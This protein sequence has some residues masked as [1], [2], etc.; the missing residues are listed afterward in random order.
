MKAFF[1][2]PKACQSWKA[3]DLPENLVC[4]AADFLQLFAARIVQF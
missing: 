1:P 4:K 3:S 2:N